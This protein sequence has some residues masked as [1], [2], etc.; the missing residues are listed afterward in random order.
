MDQRGPYCSTAFSD[1]SI[2]ELLHPN[3]WGQ[4]ARRNCLRQVYN[5]GAVR[6]GSCTAGA[7][8][9]PAGEP[10]VTVS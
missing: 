4:L 8:L 1:Y 6:S 10:A 9:T 2:Q 3:Y 5:H 7:G